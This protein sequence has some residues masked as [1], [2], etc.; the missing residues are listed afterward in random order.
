MDLPAETDER[1]GQLAGEQSCDRR[2]N[3][4]RRHVRAGRGHNRPFPAA[5][6]GGFV[7]R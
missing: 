7:M 3:A 4:G 6:R 5:A 1:V 2:G